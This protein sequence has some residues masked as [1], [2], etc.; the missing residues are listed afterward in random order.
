MFAALYLGSTGWIK[1][2]HVFLLRIGERPQLG[3]TP[4]YGDL[5]NI[6]MLIV[7]IGASAL[8]YRWIEAPARD[9]VR[10]WVSA[11]R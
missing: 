3:P 2:N 11:P 4:L 9:R 7:V 10:R 5:T 8:T 6:V 1:A